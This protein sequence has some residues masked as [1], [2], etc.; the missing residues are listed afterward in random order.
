MVYPADEK[1]KLDNILA[2]FDNYIRTH[3]YF[4]IVYSGK[5]GYVQI[6]LEE[7]ELTVIRSVQ[8]LLDV[9][10]NEI[11]ND[12]RFDGGA[13]EHDSSALSEDDAEEARRRITEILAAMGPDGDDYLEF[14]EEYLEEYPDNDIEE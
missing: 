8:K 9:L 6:Q 12:V 14:L 5:I 2:A 4:D 1:K 13:G 7:E 11:I 3:S 10:F